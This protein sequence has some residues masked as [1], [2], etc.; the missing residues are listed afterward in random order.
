M[1]QL[2]ERPHLDHLKKQAKD[3]LARYRRGD[4]AALDRF[5]NA[6]PA[7]RRKDDAT[8]ARLRLRLRDAQSCIAREYGFASWTDLASFVGARATAADLAERRLAWLRL[9]YAGDIAGGTDRPRPAVAAR[10]LAAA[11]ELAGDDPWLACAVGDSAKLRRAVRD[12]PGWIDRPGGPL[13]TLI[14]L[15]LA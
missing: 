10:L 4:A 6:L 8:L 13:V 15:H 2:P 12:D 7:A 11:P 1:A 9:I 5:R 14:P 3:L